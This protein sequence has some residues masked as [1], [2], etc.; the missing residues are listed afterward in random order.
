MKVDNATKEWSTY[1]TLAELGSAQM[2]NQ[3]RAVLSSFWLP[4]HEMAQK[5]R[6]LPMVVQQPQLS[7]I[8]SGETKNVSLYVASKTEVLA[9]MPFASLRNNVLLRDVYSYSEIS[10]RNWD[11]FPADSSLVSRLT[12]PRVLLVN[13]CV[14]NNFPIP[15]LSLSISLLASYLRKSQ[16]ADVRII[17]MQTGAT[18]ADVIEQTL[19]FKPAL[20]GMSVSYGQK[21]IAVSIIEEVYRAKKQGLINSLVVVG[22]IVPASAPDEF[23]DRYEDLVIARAEG[24]LTISGLAQYVAGRRKLGDVPGIIFRDS[25]GQNK[26]TLNVPVSVETIPLPALDTIPEMAT[27]KGALTLEIS[28]GCQWNVCTFCPRHHKSATWKTFTTAQI[29]EQFDYLGQVCDRF[30]LRRHVFL[31]DEEFMGGLDG[32]LET[33]RVAEIA[34]GL[35]SNNLRMKFDTEVRVDQV[36]DS[37]KN[38]EWHVRRMNLWH[39]CRQAGLDRLFLG[40]ESG[41]DS[42]L[43]RYG[44]GIK[45]GDSIIA[46]RLL[47]ALG[48]PLR[49]GFITFDQLMVGL[50]EI[51]ENIAFVERRD[52]FMRPV[53]ISKYGYEELF[54]LLTSDQ[55]FIH[56]QSANIPLYA[57]VSYMLATMEVLLNSSYK[58]M[59]EHTQRKHGKT[60][61]LDE[62]PDANMGRVRAAFLDPLV[63]DISESCQKW[64]DRHFALAY[65]VKSLYK[66]ASKE[67]RTTLMAWM[68]AY[69]RISLQMLK[70]LVFIFDD[71]PHKVT[72]L[73]QFEPK[74]ETSI[75]AQLQELKS[76]VKR[77]SVSRLHLMER[78]MDILDN[79]VDSQNHILMEGIRLCAITDTTDSRLSSVLQSWFTCT[80]RWILINDP[81]RINE[82]R[83]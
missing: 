5:I 41:S 59:L 48:I 13:P 45:A 58:T 14:L 72:S 18:S 51:K 78:C 16:L 47:T 10:D 20:F 1:G 44:K 77:T 15:R 2:L 30:G 61:I 34:N 76:D 49:F 42:Q 74:S 75:V 55:E 43:K 25:N 57:G 56:Q 4:P 71:D 12:L 69:R 7:L 81:S 66:I 38:R 70:S 67:E 32:G 80:K 29:L 36:Y 83:A 9:F 54:D 17:D 40:V 68:V 33:E 35:I 62:R 60:L 19:K 52:A 79:L 50:T 6:N 73:H 31:A 64:I 82:S 63:G 22:N 39:L 8:V 24:E 11:V 3:F 53:D 26:T 37:H 27:C 46:I 65:T 28:R 23:L 21:D